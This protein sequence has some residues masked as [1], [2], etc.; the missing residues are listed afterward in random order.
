MLLRDVTDVDF[1]RR[2]FRIIADSRAE[3]Y[4]GRTVIISTGASAM[5][6]GLANEQRLQGR[7]VSA[8]ATCDGAFFRDQDVAVVGGG[9]PAME[10]PLFLT[11]FAITVHVEPRRD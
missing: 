5:W 11:K 10:E 3:P 9:D 8:C 2:P 1:S 7:G 4:L 6:L